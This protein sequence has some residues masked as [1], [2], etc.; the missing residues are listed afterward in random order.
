VPHYSNDRGVSFAPASGLPS[1]VNRLASKSNPS[2]N[3]IQ[4]ASDRE[5]G[6]FYIAHF[7]AGSGAHHIYRSTNGG[8]NWSH[9]GTIPHTGGSYS[10]YRNQIV[11]AP[12]AGHVWV[13]DDGVSGNTNG[14]LW[15]ST[16][17]AVTWSGRLANVR[18]V[19]QVSF[20]KAASGSGYTVFINGYVNGLQGVYRSDD[21]GVNWTRLT[22]VPSCAA[23]ESI[24]GDRQQYGNV[25]LGTHGRGVFHGQ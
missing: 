9:A 13:S 4:V 16:D 24:A 10:Y 7:S 5:N 19:R 18:A 25:F 22:D 21:Y 23:I 15:K 3:L 17:G 2:Y 12:S 1:N 6:H 8:A 11:G 20:G 14:G